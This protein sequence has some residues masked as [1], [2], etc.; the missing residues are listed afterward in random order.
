[1]SNYSFLLLNNSLTS[2]SSST[3]IN[4][5]TL[6]RDGIEIVLNCKYAAASLSVFGTI[7][8]M[9]SYFFLCSQV[10][11][12]KKTQSELP[13][14]SKIEEEN[15]KSLK[16]GYGND[17]IFCLSVSEFLCSIVA[18]VKSDSIYDSISSDSVCVAQG[19]LSNLV[20]ISSICWTSVISAS[21]L[22]ATMSPE[23]SKIPRYYTYF[24]LYSIGVPI[25]LSVGPLLTQSYGPAGAWCWMDMRDNNDNVGQFWAILIYIFNWVNIIFNFIAIIR[26]IRYFN[27]RAFEVKEQNERESNFLRS[28]CVVLKFFPIILIICWLPATINRLYNFLTDDENVVLYSLHAFFT[29]L[30]GFLNSL[31]Y[32]FYYRNIFRLCCKDKDNVRGEQN[33]A[34]ED[35]NKHQENALRVS[36]NNMGNKIELEVHNENKFTN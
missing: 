29:Y 6:D 30:Q 32:S 21:I 17:L 10:R 16:M 35:P 12:K 28:Y 20:E 22:L 23:V 27:I 26:S 7:T 4:E 25:I 18:F 19:F 3:I 5:T 36:N 31:V 2:N 24:F 33:L 34:E 9:I 1:M 13:K 14:S 8:I 15:Y 11:C